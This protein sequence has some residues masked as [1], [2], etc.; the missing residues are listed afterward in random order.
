MDA[1]QRLAALGA[2]LL[3]IASVAVV[4]VLGWIAPPLRRALILNPYLV[5]KR[6]EVWR[7]LTA[8]WLHADVMHL[9]FNMVTLH[10]FAGPAIRT[11][12]ATTFVALY[13][14]A[15]FVA[16]VPTTLRHLHHPEYNTLGASGAVAAVMFSAILLD[17]KLRIMVMFV[18]IPIPAMLFAVGYLAF[19]A[20]Q[21]HGAGGGVNHAA[22]FAGALYGALFAFAFQPERVASAIRSLG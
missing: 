15:V 7:L 17:P 8:G 4:S 9:V 12:G 11:L 22:H 21:S 10:F 16:F 2:P 1:T 13:V 3:L 19:S 5:R 20:W 6:G 18:P 14:S